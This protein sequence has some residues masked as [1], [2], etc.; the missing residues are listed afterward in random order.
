MAKSEYKFSRDT[1]ESAAA[2]VQEVAESQISRAFNTMNTMLRDYTG[3]RDAY[4]ASTSAR[5]DRIEAKVMVEGTW[6][7]VTA[8]ITIEEEY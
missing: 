8:K 7:Y 3:D 4:V 1:S 6:Y 5:R 2:D